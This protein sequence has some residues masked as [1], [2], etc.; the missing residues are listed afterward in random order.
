[1]SRKGHGV[2]DLSGSQ[3]VLIARFIPPLP[4]EQLF[5]AMITNCPVVE[6]DQGSDGCVSEIMYRHSIAGV[7]DQ[8]AKING[9]FIN[10]YRAVA[11]GIGRTLGTI[12]MNTH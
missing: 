3:E 1:M 6:I 9:E 2:I 8:A 7:K 5:E 11:K 4:S 10:R 12:E